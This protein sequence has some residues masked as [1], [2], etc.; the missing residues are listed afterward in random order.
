LL[1]SRRLYGRRGGGGGWEGN[2]ATEGTS[3]ADAASTERC[4]L[5]RRAVGY[6]G[7]VILSPRS[8]PGS[9]FWKKKSTVRPLTLVKVRFFSLN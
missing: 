1:P 6:S 4:G 7:P 5:F 8:L 2:G 9:F 3:L